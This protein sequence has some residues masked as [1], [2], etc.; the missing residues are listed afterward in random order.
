MSGNFFGLPTELSFEIVAFPISKLFSTAEDAN[1]Q[2]IHKQVFCKEYYLTVDSNS[3]SSPRSCLRKIFRINPHYHIAFNYYH[4]ES[5][6]YHIGCNY[7]HI[8]SE[9]TRKK[10]LI[11]DTNKCGEF[12]TKFYGRIPHGKWIPKYICNFCYVNL[13][14]SK[15]YF[16]TPRIW[17]IPN[18]KGDCY[19]CYVYENINLKKVNN[20]KIY[21]TLPSSTIPYINE[22]KEE[23]TTS[24]SYIDTSNFSNL[25]NNPSFTKETHHSN[26][27]DLNQIV[28]LANMSK[29]VSEKVISK[30][31]SW[32]ITD[33]D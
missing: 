29:N 4:I 20:W 21:P 15:K 14:K 32:G 27:E 9:M 6:C 19:Y 2:T 31:K 7:Y 17:T 24:S 30:I 5:N 26:M 25:L 1:E 28:T 12:Y 11:N 3:F 23:L 22:S 10:Y 16:N 13:M 33:S 8:D 18:C